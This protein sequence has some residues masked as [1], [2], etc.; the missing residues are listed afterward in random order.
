MGLDVEKEEVIELEADLF[1][2]AGLGKGPWEP[3]E[4]EAVPRHILGLEPASPMRVRVRP[5]A[6]LGACQSR[7][8][9]DVVGEEL[10]RDVVGF[11][12]FTSL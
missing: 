9:R 5:H 10:A 2:G 4:N 11:F 7:G 12:G 6:R 1:Q 3:V 8:V